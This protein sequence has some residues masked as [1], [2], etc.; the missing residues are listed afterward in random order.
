MYRIII[1]DD[2]ESLLSGISLHFDDDP[3]FH[4]T[5]VS[6]S[7]EA[8]EKIESGEY[9]VVVSDLMFPGEA[10]GLAVIKTARSQWYSPAILAIT[11]FGSV[12]NAIRTMQSGADDFAPKGF[13]LDE[14]SI[15]IKNA[16]DKKIRGN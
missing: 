13:G 10:D 8:I 12:Q 6:N 2:D 15:R 16:I 11:A 9:D 14:I 5:T 3:D 1:C 7:S 4:V